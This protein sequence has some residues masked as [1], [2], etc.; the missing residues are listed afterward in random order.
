[1]TKASPSHRTRNV[2]RFIVAGTLAAMAW[3]FFLS[4]VHWLMGSGQPAAPPQAIELQV[5][6]LPPAPRATETPQGKVRRDAVAGSH[7][8]PPVQRQPQVERNSTVHKAPRVLPL[9]HPTPDAQQGA[10]A[11]RQDAPTPPQSNAPPA[12]GDDIAQHGMPSSAGGSPATVSQQARVLSQPLP[13]VPD[14]LREQGYQAIAVA[15]FTV[16][17]DGTFDVELVKPTQNPRLNQILLA[18]LRQWRFFPA[19]ENGRPTE[20]HQ[21]VRVHFNV[22]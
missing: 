6:E 14:D 5:M 9:P 11:A 3:W 18:T 21:D 19:I 2:R 22:N 17:A 16:H 10:T 8:T 12:P 15:R 1:M 13:E 20:T 7:G 4:Q